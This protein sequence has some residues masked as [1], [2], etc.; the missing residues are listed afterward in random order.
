MLAYHSINDLL[1][2][3][4]YEWFKFRYKLLRIKFAYLLVVY[5]YLPQSKKDYTNPPKKSICMNKE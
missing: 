1:D 3:V 2:F 4:H 5:A